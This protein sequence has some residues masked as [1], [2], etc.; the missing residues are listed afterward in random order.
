MEMS[1]QVC[2]RN[3]SVPACRYNTDIGFSNV[4]EPSSTVGIFTA[5]Q[6]I[7]ANNK[8]DILIYSPAAF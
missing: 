7:T 3:K 8:N 5:K 2:L 6:F 1:L 4:T